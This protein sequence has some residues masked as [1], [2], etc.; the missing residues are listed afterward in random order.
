MKVS[1]LNWNVLAVQKTGLTSSVID[2][3]TEVNSTEGIPFPLSEM[4]KQSHHF[5]RYF[6]YNLIMREASGSVCPLV[7]RLENSSLAHKTEVLPFCLVWEELNSQT[8]TSYT[9]WQRLNRKSSEY[10]TW[11]LSWLLLKLGTLQVLVPGSFP[12]FGRGERKKCSDMSS[13]GKL[14]FSCS[15][16]FLWNASIY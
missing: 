11:T 8:H 1:I 6:T 3:Y 5:G 14:Y 12:V 10:L 9:A 7:S 4:F 15:N 16:G 13:V 2:T